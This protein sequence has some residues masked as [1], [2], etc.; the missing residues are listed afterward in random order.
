MAD[1]ANKPTDT[2]NPPAQ[3]GGLTKEQL[4]SVTKLVNE[5]VS[6]A[7]KP[8]TEAQTE[9]AK[10]VGVIAD[11][12]K[13]LPPAAPEDKGKDAA[14]TAAQLTADDVSKQ[15]AEALAKH[16]QSQQQT[17][18]LTRNREAFVKDAKNGLARLPAEFAAKLG[19]DPSKWEAEAKGIVSSWEGFVKS[20]GIKMPDVG[21][22]NREGGQTPGQQGQAS[23]GAPQGFL[24]MPGTTAPAPA[25]A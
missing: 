6:T 3:N 18:E 12:I 19:N 5:T 13:Q 7:L 17:A 25:A 21:G 16:D 22:S 1:P 11:T 8:V 9:L 24:K 4:E 15:I 14:A 20:T 10:N 23:S 2:G